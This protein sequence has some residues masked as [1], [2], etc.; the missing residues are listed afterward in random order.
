MTL[1]FLA[2][3]SISFMKVAMVAGV[4]FSTKLHPNRRSKNKDEFV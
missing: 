4:C 3:L 2:P 1:T